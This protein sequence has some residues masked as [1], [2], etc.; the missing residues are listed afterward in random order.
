MIYDHWDKNTKIAGF[1][2][3][4]TNYEVQIN[5]QNAKTNMIKFEVKLLNYLKVV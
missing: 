4:A 5:L 1:T 3:T 2:F